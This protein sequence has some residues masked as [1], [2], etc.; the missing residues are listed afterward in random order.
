MKHTL[1]M[2]FAALALAAPVG[3]TGGHG[4]AAGGGARRAVA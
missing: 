1:T 3:G 4:R 2:T